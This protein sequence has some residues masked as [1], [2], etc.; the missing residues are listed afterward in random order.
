MGGAREHTVASGA[1]G[2]GG[3]PLTQSERKWLTEQMTPQRRK[4]A[5]SDSG[6]AW[7]GLGAPPTGESAP[8][9]RPQT[10]AGE[11]PPGPIHRETPRKRPADKG[12]DSFWSFG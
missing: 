1:P 4:P 10:P 2:N 5:P 6:D 3:R 12:E 8:P 7:P 9:A 11:H